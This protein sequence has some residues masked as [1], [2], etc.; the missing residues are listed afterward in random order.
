[1]ELDDRIKALSSD[2]FRSSIYLEDVRKGYGDI[3]TVYSSDDRF[4]GANGVYMSEEA[5]VFKDKPIVVPSMRYLFATKIGSVRNHLLKRAVQDLMFL[6]PNIGDEGLDKMADWLLQHMVRY[7]V[8]EVRGTGEFAISSQEMRDAVHLIAEGSS[9]CEIIETNKIVLYK[10]YSLLTKEDKRYYTNMYRGE[11][12]S[13]LAEELIH[14]GAIMASENIHKLMKITK[15]R[16]QEHSTEKLSISKI[17]RYMSD[18]TVKLLEEENNFRYFVTQ[19]SVD[20]FEEFLEM[21]SD[22]TPMSVYVD[23]LG[24]SYS[25]VIKYRDICK[26]NE[27]DYK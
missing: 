16:I 10:R 3:V 17:N 20:K 27:Q 15:P 12:I 18:R 7:N 1:M 23:K 4:K 5:V 24:I 25:T 26:L 14:E 6:N 22:E 11:R 13:S 2:S 8:D 19:K 9:D 21:Y